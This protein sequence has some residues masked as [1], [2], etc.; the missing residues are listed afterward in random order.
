MSCEAGLTNDTLM[1]V[2]EGEWPYTHVDTKTKKLWIGFPDYTVFILSLVITLSAT[3]YHAYCT[4]KTLFEQNN[5]ITNGVNV[6]MSGNKRKSFS[7]PA[8]DSFL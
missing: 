3:Y 6:H 1:F 5:N 8:D 7:F 2:Y 4:S